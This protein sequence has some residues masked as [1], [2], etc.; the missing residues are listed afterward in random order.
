[1]EM[2][3]LFCLIVL[4]THHLND[5]M[6]CM[7]IQESYHVMVNNSGPV[8]IDSLISFQAKLNTESV[9]NITATLHSDYH[10]ASDQSM[11]LYTWLTNAC[12]HSKQ[13]SFC[14]EN[15]TSN[16]TAVL[17]RVYSKFDVPRGGKFL[18]M[19][20]VY[21]R[22]VNGRF[23][24]IA[25]NSTY[26]I[27]TDTINGHL[28]V[29]Q[30]T[31]AI[32][33]QA[34]DVFSTKSNITLMAVITDHFSDPT[35]T[36]V[37]CIIGPQTNVSIELYGLSH[38]VLLSRRGSYKLYVAII[39]HIHVFDQMG[40]VQLVERN[41]SFNGHI[42]MKGNIHIYIYIMKERAFECKDYY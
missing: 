7:A 41:T 14:N 5:H 15:I 24:Q 37:W 4:L 20:I 10:N 6:L 3:L 16:D 36:S 13:P 26:F 27:L 29:S 39:V 8:V 42:L 31:T 25:V 35:F 34:G 28:L 11:Y 32:S 38:S 12:L 30:N 17:S 19:V 2:G 9:N 40:K 23:D 18:M 21:K 1:M 33:H 22:D